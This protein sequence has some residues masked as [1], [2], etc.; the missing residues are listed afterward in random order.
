MAPNSPTY[1]RPTQSSRS[2]EDSH[3]TKSGR[4][5]GDAV[6]NQNSVQTDFS[7]MSP[8]KQNVKNASVRDADFEDTQL[9]PRGIEIYRTGNLG[10]DSAT[11]AHA[12]F[13]SETPSDPDQSRDF[14]KNIVQ[15][16]LAGRNERDINDSIFLPLDPDFIQSVHMAYRSL[17]EAGLSES[18][19]KA[20]TFQNL[21]IG[22][23]G[24]LVNDI[25]RQ[26]CAV[27]SVEWSIKPRE[28]DRHAWHI[29]SL[30]SSQ[31]PLLKA[32]NFDIYPDC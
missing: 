12:Y 14:Y 5:R 7:T 21:L 30:L 27:R 29:P 13:G 9:I 3:T 26:F 20:Y 11:G 22:Q 24:L 4:S 18:E 31:H 28:F 19:F 32:F 1:S 23:Y 16:S 10:L 17:G 6:T 8:T 15:K 2:R 25:R